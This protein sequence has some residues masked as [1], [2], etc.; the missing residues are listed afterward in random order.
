MTRRI[1]DPAWSKRREEE[2]RQELVNSQRVQEYM[3]E[4]ER[5]KNAGYS[6]YS[7][8]TKSQRSRA[9]FSNLDESDKDSLFNI[10]GT[11]YRLWYDWEKLE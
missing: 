2:E 1:F 10:C 8:V 3:R 5:I 11:M 6:L 9:Y 4:G 7:K